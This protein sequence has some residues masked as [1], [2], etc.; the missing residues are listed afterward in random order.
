MSSVNFLIVGAGNVGKATAGHLSL[1]GHHVSIYNRSEEPLVHIR[2]KGGIDLRGV[3]N[4][5]APIEK[6]ST[7]YSEIVPDADFIVVTTPATAHRDIAFQV[8]PYLQDGQII[9]LCPGRTFGSLEF[10]SSLQ[11]FGLES[12]VVIGETQTVLY[13][14]RTLKEDNEIFAI[15]NEVGLASFPADKLNLIQGKIGQI[16]P[17][18]YPMKNIIECG[19]NN[20]GSLLH[21]VP[22]LLNMGWIESEHHCFKYYYEG[23]TPTVAQT[24][25]V[26]DLE[27]LEIARHFG[28]RAFS[29]REWL[30]ST[31]GARGATLFEALQNNPAY[32]KID[33]PTTIRHR[34]IFE[35]IPT[36]LVPLASLGRLTGEATPLTD[37]V[38]ELASRI[39]THDFMQKGRTLENLGLSD[40]NV[41]QIIQFVETGEMS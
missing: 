33:A 36:G 20:I 28:V 14:T 27:R 19:L 6:V 3:V 41:D 10:A 29:V 18:L 35:D 5:F 24:I 1:L 23:I 25:E 34:Y 12:D 37:A 8:A 2:K 9:L 26:I 32:A 22:T 13:T 40:L 15:K 11:N 31:Y 38:I 21:P 4:G 30:Q 39:F 7:N 17:Q 16:F